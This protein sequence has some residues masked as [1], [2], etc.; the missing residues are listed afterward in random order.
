MGH[1]ASTKANTL[2]KQSCPVHITSE[3]F[4]NRCFALKTHQKFSVHTTWEESVTQQSM[5]ILDVLEE[6]S[7][8]EITRLTCVHRFLKV[9]FNCKCFLSTRQRKAGFFKFLWVEERVRKGPFSKAPFSSTPFPVSLI[10]PPP[11]ASE[12]RGGNMREPGNEVAF[13]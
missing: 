7:N 1:L 3:E 13:T 2:L 12:E 9:P 4:E 5:I 11:G 8:K 6:N 10:L